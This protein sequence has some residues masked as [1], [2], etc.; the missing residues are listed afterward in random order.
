MTRG[1]YA[2]ALILEKFARE[3][4]A[5]HSLPPEGVCTVNGELVSEFRITNQY[6]REVELWTGNGTCYGFSREDLY[7]MSLTTLG[8]PLVKSTKGMVEL[9]FYRDHSVNTVT[10]IASLLY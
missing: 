9:R 6:D 4:E 7:R 1:Q 2:V 10:D 8:Y 3:P 5:V